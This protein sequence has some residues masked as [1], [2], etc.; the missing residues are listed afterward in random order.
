MAREVQEDAEPV[1]ELAPEQ[2]SAEAGEADASAQEDQA[3]AEFL[4]KTKRKYR[5]TGAGE[6]PAE[7]EE[8]KQQAAKS[9]V[10]QSE[11][12]KRWQERESRRQALSRLEQ[13]NQTLRGAILEALQEPVPQP[14]SEDKGPDP[15]QDP[16]EWYKWQIREAMKTELAPVK[17][18][19]ENEQQ[20]QAMAS[21]E[22]QRRAEF[23]QFRNRL[24]ATLAEAEQDYENTAEGKGYRDR[25]KRFAEADQ[26]ILVRAGHSPEQAAFMVAQSFDGMVKSAFQQ[27]INPAV[28]ADAF[29]SSWMEELGGKGGF[30]AP[31]S[32]PIAK[33]REAS[34]SSFATSLSQR[35]APARDA[36]NPI[37]AASKAAEITPEML[38]ELV[39]SKKGKAGYREKL[40]QV[41]AELDKQAG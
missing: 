32:K 37:R 35:S 18:W 1:E 14:V 38:Q 2:P 39:R 9:T 3:A 24:V 41:M 13:E 8:P 36:S 20:R 34:E 6:T 10:Q 5:L 25:L 33:L 28:Y 12:Q 17:G 11:A 31:V 23:E 4:E 21:Q 7:E 19:V 22:Y 16:V 26:K 30:K 40:K 15:Q 29:I 27:G